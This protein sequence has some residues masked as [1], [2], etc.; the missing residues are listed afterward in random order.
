MERAVKSQPGMQSKIRRVDTYLVDLMPER[1]RTDAIQSFVKQETIFVEVEND[2]GAV[3]VGYAYTIG[4]GG[5]AVLA[6]LRHDLLGLLTGEDA[7][8]IEAVWQKLFWSTHGTVVGAITSLALAAID[9]ALWDL[10]CKSL[11]QPLWRLAGG[12]QRGGPPYGT[13]GGLLQPSLEE[14]V[15]GASTAQKQGWPGVKGKSGKPRPGEDFEG[16]DAVR[17]AVGAD[18]DIMVHA[19]QS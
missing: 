9:T 15:G 10:R 11:G 1:P 5:R 2:E 4:T 14:P 16:L 3:G 8:Q 12:A 19:K 7:N 18:L 13:E 17:E 6:H